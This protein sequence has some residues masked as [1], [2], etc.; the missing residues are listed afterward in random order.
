[1]S[2]SLGCN[3]GDVFSAIGIMSGTM[4]EEECT[5]DNP[6][7]LV[8][9]HGTD[10]F[11]L[12]YDGNIWYQ[13]VAEI[14]DFWLDLN[15]IPAS[16]LMATE[17]N[18]GEVN[19]D[20]YF[21]GDGGDCVTLYTIINGGHDWFSEDIDGKNPNQILWDFFTESCSPI[22]ATAS[23]FSANFALEISPNPFATQINITAESPVNQRF[24]IY[25]MQ[26]ILELSGMMNG[27]IHT[28]DL[29]TLSPNVYFLEIG[30][31]VRKIVKKPF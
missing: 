6:V 13:S 7:P 9:F 25:N 26:G 2:Y 30:G 14:V 5:L 19:R 21:G 18:D 28:V 10:D 4:L 12:P 20:E 16:S 27:A 8:I 22:N 23:D 17:L 29:A 24:N 15:G 11:V 31:V 1:M 3:S